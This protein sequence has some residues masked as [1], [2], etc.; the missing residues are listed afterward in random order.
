MNKELTKKVEQ[1]PEKPGSSERENQKEKKQPEKKDQ[2]QTEGIA[3][4]QKFED[5]KKT[6]DWEGRKV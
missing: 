3:S 4:V 5:K 1:E 2:R 6:R